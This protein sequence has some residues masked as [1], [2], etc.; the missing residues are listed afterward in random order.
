MM[1][2]AHA[3][4]L[5]HRELGVVP[6]A[7]FAVAIDLADLPDV[8]AARGEQ[9]LHRV[10]GRGVQEPATSGSRRLDACDVDVGHCRAAQ[11]RRFDFERASCG[12]VLA[13][14]AQHCC[15]YFECRD[16][17]SRPPA[18][19][20]TDLAMGRPSCTVA[21]GT[22]VD[23]QS[24]R[25]RS[26]SS[27]TVD[28]MLKRPSSSPFAKCRPRPVA[29]RVGAFLP[30]GGGFTS[31]QCTV[32]MLPTN[33]APTRITAMRPSGVAKSQIKRS[34]RAKTRGTAR[35]VAAFTLNKSPGTYRLPRAAPAYGM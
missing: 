33:S 24:I 30:R 7:A 9:A 8:A 15:S 22:S 5:D 35:A 14:R 25:L 16:G 31:P 4:P 23:S 29:I 13:R 2:V 34:L 19:L 28:P 17:R 11:C 32:S 12:E 26:N 1:V 20:L 27:I 21:C 3:I 6:A 18:H 10:L